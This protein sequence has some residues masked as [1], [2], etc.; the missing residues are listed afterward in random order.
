ML[1]SLYAKLA[2]A[3]VALLTVIGAVYLVLTL[4]LAEMYRCEVSQGMNETLAEHLV[5]DL[6]LMQAGEVNEKALKEA[7]HMMMVINPSI[8]IYLLDPEGSVLAYSAPPGK[9]V[10][11]HLDLAPVRTF[12]EGSRSYPILGDDPRHTDRQKPFSAAV[13]RGEDEIQGYLYV[14]LESE[15]YDTVAQALGGSYILRLGTI[16]L[17]GSL[18]IG[19]LAGLLLFRRMTR[20]LRRLSRAMEGFDQDGVPGEISL[21]GRR[22]PEPGDE[23]D[24]LASTFRGMADRIR[25][26]IDELRRT[27]TLRRDLV[28]SVSHDLRT[29]LAALRGYLDTLILKEGKLEPERQH[30]YLSVALRHADRLEHL[31]DDLFELAKLEARLE[32]PDREP[33]PIGELV[34]DVAQKFRVPAES[35]GIRLEAEV[36]EG[37]PVVLA[38]IGLM[39]RVLENLIDNGLRHTPSGGSVRISLGPEKAGDVEVTVEDTGQGIPPDDLPHVFDAF[40]RGRDRGESGSGLGLAITRRI[41]ELHGSE[42]GVSSTPGQGAA[43]RFRLPTAS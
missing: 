12:L 39:E 7:F 6:P 25:E 27:D 41:I 13:I 33:F 2:I 15:S 24:R 26:Q 30:E 4:Y 21:P 17:G 14:V 37:T 16:L 40:F 42:I 28:A 43:F 5:A 32:P 1:R 34:Q 35:R 22:G 29:P 20:P 10:R 9:V 31:I 38:E 3:L 18:L 36:G 23:I 8:E 11:E 19:L